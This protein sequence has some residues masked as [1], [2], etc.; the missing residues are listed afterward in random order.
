M[1][2]STGAYYGD[3]GSVGVYAFVTKTHI[4]IQAYLN[5]VLQS[6]VLFKIAYK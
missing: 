3:G 2:F 6:A 4:R 1:I 5:G